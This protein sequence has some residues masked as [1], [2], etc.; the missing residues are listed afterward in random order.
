MFV[1]T[2]NKNIV[3]YLKRQQK[4]SNQATTKKFI[5]FT[6]CCYQRF[7]FVLKAGIEVFVGSA[8]CYVEDRQIPESAETAKRET[9]LFV[10]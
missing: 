3:W 1:H 9:E 7:V 8:G 10:R 2:L 6:V 5:L 4:K